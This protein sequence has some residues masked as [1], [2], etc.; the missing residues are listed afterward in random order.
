VTYSEPLYEG[1]RNKQVCPVSAIT[2][3]PTGPGVNVTDA[4]ISCGLC[5]VRC[6]FGVLEFDIEDRPFDASLSTINTR[7]IDESSFFEAIETFDVQKVDAHLFFANLIDTV[8]E[9]VEQFG[10]DEYYPFV[11][12]MLSAAGFPTELGRHGDTSDRADAI[13]H[14]SVSLVPIE[15]K[16]PTEIREINI[17]SIQQALENK[18]ILQSRRSKEMDASAPTLV[19]GHDLPLERSDVWELIEDIHEAFGISVA[20]LSTKTLVT[21]AYNNIFDKS[22]VSESDLLDFIGAPTI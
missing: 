19:V 14:T 17:K 13:M 18:T 3:K 2:T 11:A 20:I 6:R 22:S 1:L 12:S 5:A 15:I 4:C 16:S 8:Y 21:L 10:Q 7:G 9:K